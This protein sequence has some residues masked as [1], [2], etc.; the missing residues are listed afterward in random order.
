MLFLV[1]FQFG[2]F[3]I[4]HFDLAVEIFLDRF[5]FLDLFVEAAFFL[6]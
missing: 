3:D 5:I 4:D 6:D 1:F 2:A